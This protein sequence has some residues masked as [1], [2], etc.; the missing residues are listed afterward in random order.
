MVFHNRSNYDY[1]FII[2]EPAKEF[3]EGLTCLGEN[4]GKFKDV[5]SIDKNGKEVTKII[6][7]KLQFIDSVRFMVSPLSNSVDNFV[8]E[9]CK[10]ECK[11]EQNN[12][13]MQ[14]V[15]N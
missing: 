9:I 11:N 13:K 12:K 14:S 6:S 7:Y 10:I 2:K 15:W 3:N 8:D 4:A 5:K 1:R